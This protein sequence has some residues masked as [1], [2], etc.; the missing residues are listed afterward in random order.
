MRAADPHSHDTNNLQMRL[1]HMQHTFAQLYIAPHDATRGQCKFTMSPAVHIRHSEFRP[2]AFDP[3]RGQTYY[4]CIYIQ[5][6]RSRWVFNIFAIDPRC[7]TNTHTVAITHMILEQCVA[8]CFPE[9]HAWHQ[10]ANESSR[11]VLF[12][13]CWKGVAR[14]ESKRCRRS[15][16]LVTS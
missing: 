14:G 3:T 10:C 13:V 1:L 8:R 7:Q 15:Y 9:L 4:V 5:T 6:F 12:A 11:D 2:I 16:R